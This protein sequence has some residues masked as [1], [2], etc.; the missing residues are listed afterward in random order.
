MTTPD[1]QRGVDVLALMGIDFLDI[2]FR[3]ERSFA[4]KIPRGRLYWTREQVN[5]GDF[6]NTDPTAGEIH[7]RMC[8]L[9]REQNRPVPS[10]SWQRVCRCIGDCL[11]IGPDTIRPEHHLIG[12][13]GAS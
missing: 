9:L 4:V 1:C 12:E 3:L 8:E 5:R 7:A 10:E 2:V 11:G 6:P 13:L